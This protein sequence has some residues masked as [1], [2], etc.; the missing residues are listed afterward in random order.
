MLTSWSSTHR[1]LDIG[2]TVR[3]LGYRDLVPAT[4][5]WRLATRWLADNP[6]ART[7]LDEERRLLSTAGVKLAIA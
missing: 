4:T 6:L 7:D 5:A 1:V 3:D 2:P